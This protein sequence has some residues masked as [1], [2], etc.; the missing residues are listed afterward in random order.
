MFPS[1]RIS[2]ATLDVSGGDSLFLHLGPSQCVGTT[3]LPK[4]REARW[5]QGFLFKWSSLWAEDKEMGVIWLL[6]LIQI[7][8]MCGTLNAGWVSNNCVRLWD[9]RWRCY[10]EDGFDDEYWVTAHNR[11]CF[12]FVFLYQ[13]VGLPVSHSEQRIPPSVALLP[14]QSLVFITALSFV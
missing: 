12:S 1:K 3:C 9:E 11:K 8:L 10:F 14:F 7:L 4:L 13:Y 2:S 6:F 5:V